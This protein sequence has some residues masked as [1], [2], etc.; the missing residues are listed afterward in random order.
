MQSLYC[1]HCGA[2]I[3]PDARFCTYCG[4]SIP[5]DAPP[6][7]SS[8]GIGSSLPPPSESTTAYGQ[9]PMPPRRRRRGVIIAVVLV[10]VILIVG[11]VAISYLESPSPAIQVG[12]IEI[13]APDNVCGLN[14]NPIEFYGFNN[15]TGSSQTLDFGMPNYNATPCTVQSVTTN[16]S[17]FT[18]SAVQVPLSIPAN[19]SGS[20]NVTITAPST[21]FSGNMNLVLR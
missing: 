9:P 19:G 13:W 10:V 8:A 4:A 21:S 15:S 7:A 17:G 6:L 16:T 2:P 11:L 1:P 12:F 3:S 5:S 18:L 20:M 14:A